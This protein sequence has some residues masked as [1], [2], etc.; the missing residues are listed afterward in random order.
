MQIKTPRCAL[1]WAYSVKHSSQCKR[2]ESDTQLLL[3]ETEGHDTRWGVIQ[4][5]LSKM[6]WKDLVM[7]CLTDDNSKKNGNSI[8]S[9]VDLFYVSMI[10]KIVV[11]QTSVLIISYS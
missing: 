10:P 6:H 2:F 5:P 4:G 7:E 11:S 3:N 1:G 9:L 8:I